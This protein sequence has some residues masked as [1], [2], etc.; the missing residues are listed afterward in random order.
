[1]QEA[2]ADTLMPMR[3]TTDVQTAD[4]VQAWDAAS[5]WGTTLAW[6]S[7]QLAALQRWQSQDTVLVT[8]FAHDKC[9]TEFVWG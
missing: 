8:S 9:D 7:P 1:M 2:G 6:V 3:D 4:D 5:A